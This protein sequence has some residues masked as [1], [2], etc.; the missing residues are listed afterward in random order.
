M[1]CLSYIY[2]ARVGQVPRV[3]QPTAQVVV[4]RPSRDVVDHQGC[5]G[6]AVVGPCHR[7]EPLLPG[8]VPNL[9][10]DLLSRDLD[11]PRPELHADRVRTIR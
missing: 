6:P 4:R 8:S 2:R 5:R 7:P 3:G 10:L 11:D 9:Q 1:L